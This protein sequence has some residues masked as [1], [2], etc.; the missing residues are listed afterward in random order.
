MQSATHTL[1]KSAIETSLHIVREKRSYLEEEEEDVDVDVVISF[2]ALMMRGWWG[3]NV[4][5]H[6]P[7]F[8][9]IPIS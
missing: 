1:Y 5:V 8:R 4:I 7:P 9:Q 2:S 3:R 6:A